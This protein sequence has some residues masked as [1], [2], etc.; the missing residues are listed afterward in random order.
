ML[1]R[2]FVGKD[3][4]GASR[5]GERVGVELVL[6]E[7]HGFGDGSRRGVHGLLVG[8]IVVRLVFVLVTCGE[9]GAKHQSETN[10]SDGLDTICH[11]GPHCRLLS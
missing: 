6:V 4:G 8:L 5:H 9:H 3:D 1:L 2:V 11:E 7:H 10:E